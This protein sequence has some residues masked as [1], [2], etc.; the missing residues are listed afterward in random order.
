MD[1]SQFL[2]RIS[3]FTSRIFAYF[4]A[5]FRYAL[6]LRLLL[7]LTVLFSLK[8]LHIQANNLIS[9]VYSRLNIIIKSVQSQMGLNLF[10]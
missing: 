3:D 8:H 2:W 9:P 10:T 1:Y 6:G 4:G 5:L 7:H